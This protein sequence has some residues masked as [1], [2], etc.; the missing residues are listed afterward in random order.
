MIPEG[1]GGVGWNLMAECFQE[2]VDHLGNV[3]K[4]KIVAGGARQRIGVSYTGT[5]KS[6][7]SLV[8]TE[9]PPLTER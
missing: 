6:G 4:G 8:V 1:R 9:V 3:R 7:P 2:V 5:V